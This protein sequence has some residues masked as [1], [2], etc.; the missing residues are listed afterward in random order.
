VV[1]VVMGSAE[2]VRSH[3]LIEA[4]ADVV[5]VIVVH[6]VVV[7][8]DQPPFHHSVGVGETARWAAM[9]LIAEGRLASCVAGPDHSGVDAIVFHPALKFSAADPGFMFDDDREHVPSGLD[10]VGQLGECEEVVVAGEVTSGELE[11]SLPT[12]EVVGE[13]VELDQ[14]ERSGEFR[15]FEVPTELIEDEEVVVLEIAVNRAEE[16]IASAFA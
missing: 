9:G 1:P 15:W 5:T 4:L 13:F 7:R 10:P 2:A 3:E 8:Q 6:R 11:V 12:S 16:S 14:T